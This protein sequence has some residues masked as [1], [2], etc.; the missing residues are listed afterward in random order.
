M[1]L[2]EAKMHSK[3]Y[4]QIWIL[5]IVSEN[6]IK[7]YIVIYG[8]KGNYVLRYKTFDFFKFKQ[9]P[10]SFNNPEFSE[11]INNL[12]EEYNIEIYRDWEDFNAN[13]KLEDIS[14]CRQNVTV[15]PDTKDIEYE[16]DEI[17]ETTNRYVYDK[18]SEEIVYGAYPSQDDEAYLEEIEQQF[19]IIDSK[20]L[21]N[22]RNQI[23]AKIFKK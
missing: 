17:L 2:P 18:E 22:I 21:W 11:A 12:C 3:E 4:E 23:K 13:Y 15:N 10:T 5:P 14:T 20:I 6:P 19:N 8:K 16:L 7:N 9:D 1:I